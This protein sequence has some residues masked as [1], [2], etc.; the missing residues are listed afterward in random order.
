MKTSGSAQMYYKDI[1]E[2]GLIMKNLVCQIRSLKVIKVTLTGNDM[3]N[4]TCLKPHPCGH[5]M[6]RPQKDRTEGSKRL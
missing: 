2:N 6:N 4:C 5:M 3:I 1:Q